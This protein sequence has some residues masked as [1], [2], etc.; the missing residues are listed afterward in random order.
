MMYCTRRPCILSTIMFVSTDTRFL[1]IG[2]DDVRTV[3]EMPKTWPISYFPHLSHRC[4]RLAIINICKSLQYN[5]RNILK[6]IPNMWVSTEE[7]KVINLRQES[8][9][10]VPCG[11]DSAVEELMT[12][13]AD[14]SSG[15]TSK[16]RADIRKGNACLN[17]QQ[18]SLMRNYGDFE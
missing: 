2:W 18:H 10:S 14:T 12:P 6:N 13:S 1:N 9:N 4:Q 5:E 11:Q 15:I 17:C 8:A 7:E 3:A 16:F